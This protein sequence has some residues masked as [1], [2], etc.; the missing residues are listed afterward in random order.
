MHTSTFNLFYSEDAIVSWRHNLGTC[1]LHM[2]IVITICHCSVGLTYDK[3]NIDH[4]CQ[5][6][7]GTSCHWSLPRYYTGAQN[8]Y[9]TLSNR[10]MCVKRREQWTRFERKVCCCCS[11]VREGEREREM[12]NERMRDIDPKTSNN[13]WQKM[14]RKNRSFA[15]AESRSDKGSDVTN[16]VWPD[17][18]EF[19]PLQKCFGHLLKVHLVFGLIL[20]LLLHF[21]MPMG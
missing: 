10:S 13:T 5:N 2:D 21:L 12:R 9:L 15:N 1:N 6:C 17:L 11:R 20:V 14:K 4:W 16:S 19:L 8:A 3:Y 18:A 7:V